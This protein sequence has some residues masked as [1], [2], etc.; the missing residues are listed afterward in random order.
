M[1][2]DLPNLKGTSLATEPSNVEDL[3]LYLLDVLPQPMRGK[4]AG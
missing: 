4:K 2:T 3:D 1:A